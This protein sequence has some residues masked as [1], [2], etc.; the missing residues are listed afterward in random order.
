VNEPKLLSIIMGVV[1]KNFSP[2]EL[3]GCKNM[4]YNAMDGEIESVYTYVKARNEQ[5]GRP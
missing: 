3:L 1:L 4:L 5:Q 2:Y